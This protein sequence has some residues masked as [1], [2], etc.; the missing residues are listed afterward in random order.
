MVS[1][2]ARS[3]PEIPVGWTRFGEQLIPIQE[4]IGLVRG[5][6]DSVAP[7]YDLMNDLMSL[8]IHRLWKNR[9]VS[10][11]NPRQK[12]RILDVAGGTGDVAL[13]ICRKRQ[14]LTGA[15]AGGI[16]VCDVNTEM[17]EVGRNRALNEGIVGGIE[18]V[19]GNA[20]DL[21]WPDK[22][23]DAYTIAFGIRNVTDVKLALTEARRVLKPGGRF[24]CLEFSKPV[25]PAIVPF[26]NAYSDHVLPRIGECVTEDGDAY[27]YLV[28]SI[29]HFPHQEALA[30]MLGDVGLARVRYR[31]LSGG[32]AALHSAWRL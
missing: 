8:G 17:L 16:T 32:I 15:C 30:D 25:I 9:L 6:F 10:W 12:M 26:Y 23:F 27:R 7:R 22:T 29:R 4:K 13:R 14:Q 31:N 18:W 3:E 2:S 20:E 21:C 5:V 24:I 1:R 28:E 11:L 19:C